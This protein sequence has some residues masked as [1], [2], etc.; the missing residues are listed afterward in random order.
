M[1]E[2]IGLCGEVYQDKEWK[3]YKEYHYLIEK[4]GF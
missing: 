3:H 1:F 4:Y 2:E